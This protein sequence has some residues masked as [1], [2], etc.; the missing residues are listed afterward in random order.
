M[1]YLEAGVYAEN[2]VSIACFLNAGFIEQYRV[3]NKYR[4]IDSFEEVI[5]F[6]AINPLFDS[7]LLK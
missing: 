1:H 5:F 4:H 3:D 7:S 6:A 2:V